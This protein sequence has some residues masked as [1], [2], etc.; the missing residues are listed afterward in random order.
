M[1]A[2]LTATTTLVHATELKDGAYQV[3]PGDDIQSAVDLAARDPSIKRVLVHPGVYAPK[4]PSQALV[5]L[6]RTHDGIRLEG[7]GRP[8]LT[9]ANPAI[10]VPG[11]AS[12]AA[13][14]NHVLYLGDGI[15]SNTVIA[16]FKLT[17]ASHFVT[18]DGTLRMEPDQKFKKGRFYFGDGGAVKIYHRSF[19]VLR[20]L[21]ITGNY[22][23]PCAGG[24]SIQHEE[25]GQGVV[26]IEDCIFRGN[27]SEVTGAALDLLWGS[28][29]RVVNCLFEGN[30]SNTGPG[31]GENPFNNNGAITV[32]PR[33]RISMIRCTITGN[34]NGVD[35]MSGLG[36]YAQCLFEKNTLDGGF[37][38][39]AR[40]ELHLE[41]GGSVRQCFIDGPIRDPLSVVK[42]SDNEFA[43]ADRKLRPPGKFGCILPTAPPKAD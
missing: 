26:V 41:R 35:D 19:P 29:A 16:H 5:F 4:H 18:T 7:V 15:S 27:R 10:A 1:A 2:L 20:D 11:A 38:P 34:R 6:N 43:E 9:A 23:S 25:I 3:F 39:Q 28:T 37:T 13:V 32:F 22:A 33:S 42:P 40:Y 31:E 24:I 36:D 12:G 14:V 21:E 30:V 8:T 17:G